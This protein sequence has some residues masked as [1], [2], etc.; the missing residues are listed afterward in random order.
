VELQWDIAREGKDIRVMWARPGDTFD[1][2]WMEDVR[3]TSEI[4]E[5]DHIGLGV[6]WKPPRPVDMCI[7][8]GVQTPASVPLKS[9]VSLGV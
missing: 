3:A 7:A 1:L 2:N 9:L 4:D 8:F 6:S 5:M